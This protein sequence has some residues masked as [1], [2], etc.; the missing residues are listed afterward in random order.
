MS[1]RIIYCFPAA[2]VYVVPLAVGH[3][4]PYT[5]GVG[6]AEEDIVEDCIVIPMLDEVGEPAEEPPDGVLGCDEDMDE[7]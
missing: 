6:D 2:S 5:E 1:Q 7:D 3:C 4:G